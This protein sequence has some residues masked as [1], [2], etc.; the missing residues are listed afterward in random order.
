MTDPIPL[1]AAE[2]QTA[3][4]ALAAA[5]AVIRLYRSQELGAEEAM[6]RI[7]R[8]LDVSVAGQEIPLFPPARGDGS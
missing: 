8:A 4:T 5:K 6:E 3:E 7:V 2:G 1:P